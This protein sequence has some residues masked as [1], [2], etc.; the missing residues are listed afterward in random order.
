MNIKP[1][2]TCYQKHLLSGDM[3]EFTI[4]VFHFEFGIL[5]ETQE[6]RKYTLLQIL[7]GIFKF[8]ANQCYIFDNVLILK[9]TFRSY[10]FLLLMMIYS[11]SPL[12]F[13][14]SVVEKKK[15]KSTSVYSYSPLACN[16]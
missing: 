2:E 6:C 10:L 12:H 3:K 1:K 7:R 13:L 4:I 14:L 16:A 5:K 11:C 8:H 9:Q 15:K